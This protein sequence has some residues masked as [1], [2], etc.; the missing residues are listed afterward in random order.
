[1]RPA[2]F[3]VARLLDEA[4][5][6][7]TG[8]LPQEAP[9]GAVYVV[10]QDEGRKYA[11]LDDYAQEVGDIDT[12]I[13][14]GAV[15]IQAH[16]LNNITVYSKA[17]PVPVGTATL[18]D[19]MDELGVEI[20][21]NT[22]WAKSIK[23]RPAQSDW[24]RMFASQKYMDRS[25]RESEKMQK[26]VERDQEKEQKQEPKQEPPKGSKNV[27]RVLGRAVPPAERPHK[28]DMGFFMRQPEGQ[29]GVEVG[30]IIR[31]TAAARSGLEQGDII[32]RVGQ[33][34]MRNGGLAP[35]DGYE[36]TTHEELQRIL[37][38]L[39]PGTNFPLEVLRGDSW[40]TIV[41]TPQ[42]QVWPEFEAPAPKPAAPPPP[43]PEPEP[44]QGVE[45]LPSHLL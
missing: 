45:E 7:G 27:Q 43:A 19:M 11:S 25:E 20:G 29:K 12:A 15:V 26:E 17:Y 8:E 9:R 41:L 2:R 37:G 18:L 13:Q 38:W 28:L 24:R 33:F 42:P 35:E 1:M 3:I 36:I 32:R 4:E 21:A 22:G 30:H 23:V 40:E 16:D 31:G 14:R 6:A 10:Q 44:E 5:P 39:M 34:Q